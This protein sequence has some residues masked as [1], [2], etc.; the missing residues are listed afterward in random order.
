MTVLDRLDALADPTRSRLLLVLDRHELAVTELCAVVQLPQSTVS[1]HLRILSDA[2]WVASRADGTSRQYRLAAPLEP[3]ARRLWQVV[4]E[5]LADSAQ[6]T[7]DAARVR[8]V[9]T[10]RQT[11]SR[12]FFSTAAGQWDGLRAELFGSRTDVA[13]L[14]A[15]LDESWT[16]G[17]LGCGTGHLTQALA[18]FV[19]RVVGVDASKAMLAVARRRLDGSANV[20]LRAGELESLPVEDQELDA[21]VMYLVLHYVAEPVAALTE[22]RRTLKPGCR[23]LVVDMMPHDRAEYRRQMGHVWQGFSA[24]T[25]GGWVTDAGLGGFRYLAL[26]PDTTA[27]GPALFAATARRDA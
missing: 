24:D 21:A 6:A 14:P 13:A 19:R 12:E 16:V 15:L 18:P 17:D 2:G 3:A 11:A 23:V 10:R 26:P 27:K 7:Q 4:R 8:S 22:V 5:E 20:E 9:L 1:R 25:L